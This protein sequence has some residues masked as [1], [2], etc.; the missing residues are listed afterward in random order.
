MVQ[1]ERLIIRSWLDS[2]T[3]PL[4]A[5]GADAEFVRYLQGRPWTLDDAVGMIATCRAAEESMG[6]TLWA[7]EDR[8]TGVLVGYCGF[9]RT[10]ASCVRTDVIE[11]GWGIGRPHWKQG[12]A[13]EAATAVL[14]LASQRFED[15]VVV[16]KCHTDNVASERVM[17]RIGL[18]RAGLVQ[19]LEWPTTIY[20]S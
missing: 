4:A 10:N 16:A 19:Y 20:R 2:D 3:E 12:Y 9:G 18:R 8:A 1:T 17:Q 7:L 14:P 11:M 5:M 6:L 15:A 13:T